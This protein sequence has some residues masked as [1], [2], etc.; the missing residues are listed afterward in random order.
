[1]DIFYTRKPSSGVRIRI[2]LAPVADER[3]CNFDDKSEIHEMRGIIYAQHPNAMQTNLPSTKETSWLA[4]QVEPQLNQFCH[5]HRQPPVPPSMGPLTVP[6]PCVLLTR[7][8]P[9]PRSSN[10]NDFFDSSSLMEPSS[11]IS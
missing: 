8:P 2:E 10:W 5:W 3:G 4:S 1:M 6:C 7:L 9:N 11:S